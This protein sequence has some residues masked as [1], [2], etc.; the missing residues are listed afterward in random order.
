[1]KKIIIV[2]LSVFLLAGIFCCGDMPGDDGGTATYTVTFESRGGSSVSSV[3]AVSLGASITEPAAP[4][5]S[6]Y[7]FSGW[8]TEEGLTNEW[9]FTS[10]TVT[11]NLTLYA[12]WCNV[13][14]ACM[15]MSN[16]IF[17]WSN[18]ILSNIT[19]GTYI[20]GPK[21]IYVND[22]DIYICGFENNAGGIAIAK[23]WKNGVAVP[24][25]DGTY[26]A[27]ATSIIV[28]GTDVYVSG[29]EKNASD[30][31][32]AKYWKN[33]TAVELNDGTFNAQALDLSVSGSDVF[34]GGYEGAGTGF[35][36]A[37]YWKNN[38]SGAV[39]LTDGSRTAL[40]NSIKIGDTDVYCG[41]TESDGATGSI[42]KYWKNSSE[43]I[44]PG[45]FNFSEVYSIILNSGNV[46]SAGVGSD[47]ST[48]TALYWKNTSAPVVLP[49]GFAA[50]EIF[51]YRDDIYISGY[52]QTS[53]PAIYARYWLN[54]EKIEIGDDIAA[55]SIFV[56]D[57]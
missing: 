54:G 23:Y 31:D 52:K 4:T 7:T 49:D 48:A 46:Y 16:Q 40:V 27:Q 6:G 12:G 30:V 9:D 14:A 10:D 57:E 17:L 56:T 41:G 3:T 1:M 34:I 29:Y 50:T 2:L 39:A 11:S 26:N 20:A 21:S 55:M 15:N 25:T 53:D 43:N 19:D 18:G 44:L 5:K 32:I 51:I 38:S 22:G 28:S 47:G 37:K 8:Y 24:L 35:A 33:G 13:Y 45:T 36:V 42:A